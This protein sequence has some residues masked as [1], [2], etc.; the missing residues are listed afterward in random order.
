M[1]IG[2]TGTQAG[3][4]YPQRGKFYSLLES[5]NCKEFHH[6]DCIGADSTAHNL[7]VQYFTIKL[8]QNEFTGKIIIHPPIIS[9][10]R[11]FCNAKTIL[12]KRGYLDRNHDIVDSCDILLATPKEVEEQL[13]SGTWA[14][15]RY[16]RK[17][18]KRIIIIFPDGSA[19]E[20]E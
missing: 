18:G 19:K 13:R 6:G 8:K 14:T 16:A 10:K 1:K 20:S 12:P 17:V 11:A 3:M 15:I 5:L 7:V 2:F 4:T 9:N